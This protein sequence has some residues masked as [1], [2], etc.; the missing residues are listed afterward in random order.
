MVLTLKASDVMSRKYKKITDDKRLYELA[1]LFDE[2]TDVLF[3]YD[4]KGCYKGI[5]TERAIARTALNKQSTKAKRLVIHAPKISPETSIIEAS[6]LMVE[7][8][9]MQLP[10]EDKS[11][12][13]GVVTADDILKKSAE[14]YFGSK[15]SEEVMSK[16]VMVCSPEDK[17]KR[18]LNLFR[19]YHISRLPVVSDGELTG[20]ISM[21]DI[22]NKAL[23]MDIE[24]DVFSESDAK[25]ALYN[26]NVEDVM[27]YTAETVKKHDPVR[28]AINKMLDYDI[29]AVIV[30]NDEGMPAGIITKR[31]LLESILLLGKIKP[32]LQVQ[33]S[34]K[35]R[36]ISKES[37]I[38][39]IESFAKT[40]KDS[41]SQGY[42]YVYLSELASRN[43]PLI[44]CRLRLHAASIRINVTGEG[45][46]YTQALDECL[47]RLRLRLIKLKELIS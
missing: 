32:S 25:Q 47:D 42:V 36:G 7:N 13:I 27:T 45:I 37:V 38:K 40:Y 43:K 3:V 15:K 44:Q 30:V 16:D 14:K 5:L 39:K 12:I 4:D 18:V 9:V 41:L 28:E 6:R 46:T 35:I 17:I 20:I 21:H 31:D 33:V 23:Q 24:P 8:D 19:D 26:M 1:S 22:V 2:E 10:V 34:S 29:S 11:R